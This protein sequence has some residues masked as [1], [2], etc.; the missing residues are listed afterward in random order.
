MIFFAKDKI[1]LNIQTIKR[2]YNFFISKLDDPDK[3]GFTVIIFN[4]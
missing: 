2:P 1:F 4:N 3:S